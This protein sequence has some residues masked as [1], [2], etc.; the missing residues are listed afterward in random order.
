[1]TKVIRAHWQ[2]QAQVDELI[3]RLAPDCCVV[4]AVQNDDE[5]IVWDED[6]EGLGRVEWHVGY[7][8]APGCPLGRQLIPHFENAIDRLRERYDLG[9]TCR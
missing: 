4:A 1:M 5:K 9:V 2:L 6:C 8:V 7:T 3:K